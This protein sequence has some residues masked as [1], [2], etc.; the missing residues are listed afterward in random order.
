MALDPKAQAALALHRF[1]LGP[2][3][4]S[5][6]AMASD[7]RGALIAEL[8]RP[9]V[10]RVAAPDLMSTGAAARAAAEFREAQRQTRREAGGQKN[11]QPKNA[12]AKG[13]PRQR[14]SVGV[15][16]QELYSHRS[17]GAARQRARGRH[18]I[19]RAPHLVLVE[20]LLRS[21]AAPARPMAG[22]FEREAIR[23]HVLGRFAE[24]LLA[25]EGHPG[26]LI[27]LDNPTSIGPN[28]LPASTTIAA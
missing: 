18:R 21:A 26:M 23:P 14:P 15:A 5:I 16:P 12:E 28:S 11:A 27:Y 3:T 4:G 7:P 24:M 10:G 13:T 19:C 1:G 9:N 6:A 22:A 17:Q 25:V 2:R 8:D 20:P